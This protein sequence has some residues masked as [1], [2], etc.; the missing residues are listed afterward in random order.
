M[1]SKV[2]CG[3]AAKCTVQNSAL[4]GVLALQ[5]NL[6][7]VPPRKYPRDSFFNAQSPE[8]SSAILI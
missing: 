4:P 2:T 7:G 1:N 3:R 5:I 8:L 6:S